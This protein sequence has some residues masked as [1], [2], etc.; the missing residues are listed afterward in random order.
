VHAVRGT[1]H[2]EL[3]ETPCLLITL[4]WLHFLPPLAIFISYEISTK[5]VFLVQDIIE[6]KCSEFRE[7][8]RAVLQL[9]SEACTVSTVHV[10]AVFG[11]SVWMCAAVSRT[12]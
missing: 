2:M 10:C 11:L 1:S 3:L 9:N 4:S 12:K 7:V 8:S 5:V 6:L